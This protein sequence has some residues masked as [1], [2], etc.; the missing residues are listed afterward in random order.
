MQR[1]LCA[2]AAALVLLVAPADAVARPQVY[3]RTKCVGLY[4]WPVAEPTPRRKAVSLRGAR[5]IDLRQHHRRRWHDD[6]LPAAATRDVD[7]RSDERRFSL[8]RDTPIAIARRYL[9][10]NPTG[11]ARAWCGAFMRL[12]MRAAGYPDLP[13]GNL[14]AAWRRYGRPNAPQ[15]GAIVVW[16]HHVG[17]ITALHGAGFATVISGND[18][19][20]V[21]ERPRS[22]AGA[23]AFRSE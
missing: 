8:N 4:C 17:L 11:W 7:L 12:V 1:M 2:A 23:I 5:S 18:G 20:R 16:R 10:G 21:R 3:Y 19:H 22:I 13:S 6:D 9:G 15:P 14:A